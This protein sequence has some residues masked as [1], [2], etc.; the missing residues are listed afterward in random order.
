ML[1]AADVAFEAVPA[2]IDERAIEAELSDSDSAEIALAIAEAKA[3][4][5]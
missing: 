3:L 5:V 1:E 2:A 4:A